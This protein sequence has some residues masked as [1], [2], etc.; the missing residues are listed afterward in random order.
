MLLFDW[1]DTLYS[2]ILQEIRNYSCFFPQ[3]QPFAKSKW[4]PLTE[5]FLPPGAASESSKY[6]SV[7][8]G[9]DKEER[10]QPENVASAPKYRKNPDAF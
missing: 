4:E 8:D 5:Q 6:G 7:N 10:N 3:A 2:K 1:L 9:F